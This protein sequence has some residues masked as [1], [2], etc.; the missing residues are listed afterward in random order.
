[1]LNGTARGKELKRA[2]Q[3]GQQRASG[4]DCNLAVNRTLTTNHVLPA[5]VGK[6]WLCRR[7]TSSNAMNCYVGVSV[8]S[9]RVHTRRYDPAASVEAS[10]NSRKSSSSSSWSA[11]SNSVHVPRQTCGKS[12]SRCRTN[13][14]T[15]EQYDF[16]Q[17]SAS[18]VVLKSRA[19]RVFAVVLLFTLSNARACKRELRKHA[20]R[21]KW[22]QVR[23]T[24]WLHKT[25]KNNNN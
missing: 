4:G 6:I 20:G 22:D 19:S 13:N 15:T 12:S 11:L 16:R 21:W 18:N 2:K 5:W 25:N 8:S 24:G 10:R 1:M 7:T 3:A 17:R 14:D 23:Y 9:I